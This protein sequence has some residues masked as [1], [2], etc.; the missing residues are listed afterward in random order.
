[1]RGAAILKQLQMQAQK[2][3]PFPLKSSGGGW[4]CLR[5][6]LNFGLLPWSSSTCAKQ[7][8]W[9]QGLHCG[10]VWEVPS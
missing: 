3:A 1:M 6:R 4:A 5:L 2:I 7:S 9:L 10:T 8:A